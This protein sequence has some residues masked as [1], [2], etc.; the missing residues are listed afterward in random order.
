MKYYM[1]KQIFQNPDSTFYE[2]YI[3]KSWNSTVPK[4]YRI[5]AHAKAALTIHHNKKAIDDAIIEVE[6]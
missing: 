2:E 4:M 3:N 5:E 6:V 1:A